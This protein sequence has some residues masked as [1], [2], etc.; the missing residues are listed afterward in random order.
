[1]TID[2]WLPPAVIIGVLGTFHTI[3]TLM[4]NKRIEDLG[5]NVN[6][7]INDLRSQMTREHDSLARRVDETNRILAETNTILVSHVSNYEIHKGGSEK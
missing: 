5:K 2:T 6:D 7:R 3:T 4:L 1:M